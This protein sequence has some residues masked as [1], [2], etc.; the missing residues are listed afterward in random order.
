[1]S[2]GNDQAEFLLDFCL[3]VRYASRLCRVTA[4]ELDRTVDQQRIYVE[5][6]RS[7]TMNS[8]H[9]DRMAG[10]LN[11]FIDGVYVNS[12]GDKGLEIIKP[13]G[14]FWESLDSKNVWGGNFDRDHGRKDPWVDLGHFQRNK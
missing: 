11:F 4:G 10:D 2:L 3:L 13:I 9:L 1:M 12:L 8:L 5:T 7:K 14:M 6:G